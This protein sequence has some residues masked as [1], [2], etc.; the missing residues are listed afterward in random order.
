MVT[1]T[2]VQ[3]GCQQWYSCW[4]KCVKMEGYYVTLEVLT[5]MF[6]KSSVFCKV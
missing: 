5:A 3:E 6:G 4:Q 1:R 2:D